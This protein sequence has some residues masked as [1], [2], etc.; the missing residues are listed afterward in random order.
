MEVEVLEVLVVAGRVEDAHLGREREEE[1]RIVAKE[2]WSQCPAG[3]G[4]PPENVTVVVFDHQYR[5]TLVHNPPLKHNSKGHFRSRC[6]QSV[7]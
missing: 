3:R 5:W 6:I 2:L 1:A 7:K 4:K